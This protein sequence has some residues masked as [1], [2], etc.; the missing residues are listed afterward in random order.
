MGTPARSRGHMLPYLGIFS[1][2]KSFPC[3]CVLPIGTLCPS[4]LRLP[5]PHPSAIP[6]AP[7]CSPRDSSECSR[8]RGTLV[9]SDQLLLWGGPREGSHSACFSARFAHGLTEEV[10]S[11]K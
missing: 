5:T 7:E 8:L 10:Q 9:R 4:R 11:G 2:F 3:S 6:Q 1:F